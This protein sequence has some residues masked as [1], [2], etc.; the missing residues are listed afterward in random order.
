MVVTRQ[1]A[2]RRENRPFETLN[3]ILLD[4]FTKRRH[5]SKSK[6]R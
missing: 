5:N 4:P 6:L 1:V 2:L 3:L